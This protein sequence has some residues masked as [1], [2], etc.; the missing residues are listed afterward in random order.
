MKPALT[1]AGS[2]PIAVGHLRYVFEHERLSAPERQAL[3][4]EMHETMMA[5][6]ESMDEMTTVRVRTMPAPFPQEGMPGQPMFFKR[7]DATRGYLGV[8]FDGPSVD[9]LRGTERIIRFLDYPRI[10]LVEPS[11]PAEQAGIAEGDTLIELNGSDVR[12]R[13]FSLTKLLV[14][15]QRVRLKVRRDGAPMNFRITVAEVPGYVVSR[16]VPMPPMP[17]MTPMPSAPTSPVRVR[18]Y[19]GDVPQ[20][21]PAAPVAGTP[22]PSIAMAWVTQDGV[23]GARLE[24]VSE[25]LGRALGTQ[26]GVL[27]LRSAPGSPAFDSGLRDG[28]V[29]LRVSGGNVRSVRDL[30]EAI[31]DAD[32][33][34]GVKLVVLREK[35][36]REITLRW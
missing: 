30:R 18:V 36:Q 8:S 9:E 25:G 28:D 32:G 14:P 23:A 5:L 10:A 29:I 3:G 2:E 19:T 11:S 24:S 12:D 33:D 20:P 22:Q 31:Q 27:V 17:V 26:Y 35:R 1:F 6:Q 16:M 7:R 13:A 21:A 34:D 4:D 15:R